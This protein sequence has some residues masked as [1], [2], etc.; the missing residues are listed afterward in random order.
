M[1]KP[2][3]KLR[4]IGKHRAPP[5]HHV[6]GQTALGHLYLERDESE[7]ITA[8]T[9]FG[10]FVRIV[11]GYLKHLDGKRGGH[12]LESLR[13]EKDVIDVISTL[14]PGTTNRR[15]SLQ[16]SVIGRRS[17]KLPTLPLKDWRK[18]VSD[19]MPELE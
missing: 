7:K 17:N 4:V 6:P 19:L 13:T 14:T 9:A 1:P 11:Q 2:L 18:I 12:S 15:M 8:D 5:V 10:V 3:K 16:L